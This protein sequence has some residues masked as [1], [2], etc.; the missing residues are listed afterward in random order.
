MVIREFDQKKS[1]IR[2]ICYVLAAAIFV[3]VHQKFQIYIH[4]MDETCAQL[5]GMSSFMVQMTYLTVFS[6]LISSILMFIGVKEYREASKDGFSPSRK[7]N[8]FSKFKISKKI[9][10]KIKLKMKFQLMIYGVLSVLMLSIP[11]NFTLI[12][13][14]NCKHNF[15]SL[16]ELNNQYHAICLDGLKKK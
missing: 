8:D 1:R 9:T 11:L 5:R 14:K 6:I 4:Q 2:L 15:D 10:K 16:S 3:V 7:S 12:L 13:T